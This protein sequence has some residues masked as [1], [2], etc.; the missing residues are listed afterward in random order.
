MRI[1]LGVVLLVDL[2]DRIADLAAL[3]TD[4]GVISLAA[5]REQ[6]AAKGWWSLHALSGSLGWV[7]VLHAIA[8]IA[9]IALTAGYRTR[10]ASFMSWVLYVSLTNRNFL[11]V[12]P[13]DYLMR[14]MLLWGLCLPW[15]ARFSVDARRRPALADRPEDVL[16]VPTVGFFL[17]TAG[18]FL[19]AGLSKTGDSWHDGTALYYLFGLRWFATGHAD[20]LL[21]WP[22]GLAVLTH[23]SVWF[24]LLSPLLLFT[25]WRNGL[26]RTGFLLLATLQMI[27]IRFA[28]QTYL[29]SPIMIAMFAGMLPPWFWQKLGRH[30][31]IVRW[32]RAVRDRLFPA[33][34]TASTPSSAPVRRPFDEG[35]IAGAA[36]AALTVLMLYLEA[37]RLRGLGYKVPEL[38]V[39][40]PLE[41]VVQAG[42]L[43]NHWTMFD[44][45][46]SFGDFWYVVEAT[47][48]D[49]RTYDPFMARSVDWV[50]PK[51][52]PGAIPSFRWGRYMLEMHA[53]RRENKNP[54]LFRS[55]Y[56]AYL[57]RRWDAEHPPEAALA[58]VRLVI[59][60]R[61]GAGYGAPPPPIQWD[62]VADHQFD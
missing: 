33:R 40:T 10:L 39:P 6:L 17:L 49:G 57:R 35:P 16:S 29:L 42:R 24:E 32:G 38:P 4:G 59:A 61:E 56:V 20:F 50:M 1:V 55:L 18:F 37:G 46:K 8:L 43:R 13:G 34:G 53:G 52:I 21:A 47:A 60:W 27:A 54:Q 14:M 36:V 23:L 41:A 31:G 48:K 26:I 5:I 62:V 2:L 51:D 45:P 30:E 28:M 44:E 19:M 12:Y 7:A 9:A 3:Y 22:G 58:R 25:P 11:A 15:A